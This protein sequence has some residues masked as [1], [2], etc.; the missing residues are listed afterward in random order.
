M[1]A[2]H[3]SLLSLLLLPTTLWAQ[4]RGQLD[5]LTLDNQPALLEEPELPLTTAN[6]LGDYRMA[7]SHCRT[8]TNEYLDISELWEDKAEAHISFQADS[9]GLTFKSEGRIDTALWWIDGGLFCGADQEDR[10]DAGCFAARLS[11]DHLLLLSGFETQCLAILERIHTEPADLKAVLNAH[12][13]QYTKGL[14]KVTVNRLKDRIYRLEGVWQPSYGGQWHELP[15]TGPKGMHMLRD[16]RVAYLD[17][18]GI[19]GDHWGRWVI[20]DDQLS[21]R[22]N[23][24][25]PPTFHS[26]PALVSD[27]YLFYLLPPSEGGLLMVYRIQ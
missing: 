14:K 25:E 15:P 6:V 19:L 20:R 22:D 18:P 12:F 10:D 16:S 2:F 23:Q 17:G 3:L 24:D 27:S 26:Y 5:T 9:L 11:E 8:E 13:P 1:K 7:S 21:L 4:S